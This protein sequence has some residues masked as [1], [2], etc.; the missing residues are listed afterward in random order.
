MQ[1]DEIRPHD[2]TLRLD[3]IDQ[4]CFNGA[5]GEVCFGFHVSDF[6]KRIG[7]SREEAKVLFNTICKNFAT[8]PIKLN[9]T[10]K[11]L[12]A[13]SNALKETMKELGNAGEFHA[14]VGIFMEE[15]EQIAASLDEILASWPSS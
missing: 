9:L 3:Q 7:I 13:V 12:Q 15:A 4:L 5:L 1:T 10:R 6:A 14:R 8:H 2:A 11:Q